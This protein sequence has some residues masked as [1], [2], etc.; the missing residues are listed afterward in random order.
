VVKTS[1]QHLTGDTGTL[2]TIRALYQT[3]E[4]TLAAEGRSIVI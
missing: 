1:K 4:A 3:N 2:Q